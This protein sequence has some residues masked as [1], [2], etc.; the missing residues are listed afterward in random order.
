MHL[1]SHGNLKNTSRITVLAKNYI[2]LLL[3]AVKTIFIPSK[4]N[5]LYSTIRNSLVYNSDDTQSK[6]IKIF[7]EKTLV[8]NALLYSTWGEFHLEYVELI[9]SLFCIY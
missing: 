3:C 9:V 4:L 2:W 1:K 8:S 5:Y 6:R 7:S